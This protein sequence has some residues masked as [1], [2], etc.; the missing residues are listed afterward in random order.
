MIII[1][2]LTKIFNEESYTMC[3]NISIK[4]SEN[5][6]VYKCKSCGDIFIIQ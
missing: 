4:R 6:R 2:K 5:T 1:L 3:N